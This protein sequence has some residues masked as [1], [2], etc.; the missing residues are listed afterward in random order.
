MIMNL[1]IKIYHLFLFYFVSYFF[2]SLDQYLAGYFEKILD[3]IF[4][5]F[6]DAIMTYLNDLGLELFM[7]FIRHIYSYSIMQLIQ[8]LLLPHLPFFNLINNDTEKKKKNVL[9]FNE[10]L[11]EATVFCNWS[12]K[13]EICCILIECMCK[14]EKYID[15][16]PYDEW[17]KYIEKKKAL[18]N[19]EEV[20]EEED[21]VEKEGEVNQ[22]LLNTPIH[23]SDL[24]IT[25]FQLSG[26]TVLF[27]KCLCKPYYP[28]L[29]LDHAFY[30]P[31]RS[32]EDEEKVYVTSREELDRV[33]NSDD[34]LLEK[35]ISFA[36]FYV[37][38]SFISRLSDYKYDIDQF[39]ASNHNKA[40]VDVNIQESLDFLNEINPIWDLFIPYFPNF[41]TC[42][43]LSLNKK[44]KN[45]VYHVNQ[46]LQKFIPLGHH[47]FQVIKLIE[48]LSRVNNP[49][50]NEMFLSHHILTYCLNLLFKY[51][52]NSVLHLTIYRIFIPFLDVNTTNPA[53][54]ARI[55]SETNL[56]EV[57]MEHLGKTV[58]KEEGETKEEDT[59]NL[60]IQTL[61]STE[62]LEE[63]DVKS[64]NAESEEKK[65]TE[66]EEKNKEDENDDTKNESKV[67]Y[68]KSLAYFHFSESYDTFLY[69]HSS[70]IG[71]LIHIAHSTSI[72]L[73]KYNQ[74][75]NAN[76]SELNDSLE[77]KSEVDALCTE[78]IQENKNGLKIRELIE[79]SLE[80]NETD[81]ESSEPKIEFFPEDLPIFKKPSKDVLANWDKFAEE[82]L[83]LI[84]NHQYN[85]KYDASLNE[86]NYTDSFSPDR[87]LDTNAGDMMNDFNYNYD[88][89][90]DDDDDETPD[91]FSSDMFEDKFVS[92]DLFIQEN[93]YDDEDD[94]FS[95]SAFSS[96]FRNTSAIEGDDNDF[97]SSYNNDN[98]SE[99]IVDQDDPFSDSADVDIF[100]ETTTL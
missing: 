59:N 48:S 60:S 32:S 46:A 77:K 3:L 94:D 30:T 13:E 18:E 16:K 14:P 2:L 66:G 52:F 33:F 25:I 8:R 57:L 90:R 15:V 81:N 51:D 1:V 21:K 28:T 62:N 23:I 50:I 27:T 10:G 6:T 83:I 78:E 76:T 87:I 37:L 99:H 93:F 79:K 75:K 85:G 45:E 73:Q 69:R 100:S 43:S 47:N 63:V 26:P 65:E 61:N 44:P 42:L 40:D 17:L 11:G 88:F 56:L 80:S 24:L 35:N 70:L 68:S 97:F 49:T 12:S 74:V 82:K 72:C 55:L 7:K 71:S 58:P 34:E 4:R 86:L 38:D 95:N 22:L 67:D 96:T 98:I 20:V 9:Q 41:V 19:G 64:D 36:C 39:L 84:I 29:L 92:N 54:V 91:L 89:D 5:Y 31:T 53:I